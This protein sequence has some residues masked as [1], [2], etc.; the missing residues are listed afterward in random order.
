MKSNRLWWLSLVVGLLL[1]SGDRVVRAAEPVSTMRPQIAQVENTKVLVT[2][3]ELERSSTG[4]NIVLETA[5]GQTL[6]IDRSKFTTAGNAIVADIPN[7]ELSNTQPFEVL[8]P[9]PDI[10]VIRVMPIDSDRLQISVVGD[11]TPPTTPVSLKVGGSSYALNSAPETTEQEVEIVVRGDGRTRYNVPNASTATKTDT[12]LRDVPQSIQVVPRQIIEDQGITRT[13]DALRNTSGISIQGGYGGYY[14][15]V[16]VRGFLNSENLKNGFATQTPSPVVNS[17]NI[18]QIEVL[19]GPASVLYGQSQ[20]GGVVNYVT[21]KPLE[22]P[23]RSAEVKF[24]SFNTFSPSIDLSGPLD[25]NKTLL[26]RFN[27]NYSSTGSFIDFVDGN[28]FNAAVALTYKISPATTIDLEY[29]RSDDR[30]TFYDGLPVSPVAFQLPINSFFGDPNGP[31]L[32]ASNNNLSLAVNHKF[33]DDLK[34]RSR[35]GA[36]FGTFANAA[37]RPG[38]LLE[39]QR[40]LTL[41]FQEDDKV[42]IGN[43]AWQTDLI[44]KFTTGSIKHQ[45][46]VG[47]DLSRAVYGED[48]YQN[49]SADPATLP[50]IDI[51]NPVYGFT[52]PDRSQLTFEPFRNERNS[53]GIYA[54]DQ[55]ELQPNLKLLVGG[56]F[57]FVDRKDTN[58]G[59]VSTSYDTAFTPR[60][61]IVYQPIQPISLYASYAR[62]FSPSF[63]RTTEGVTLPPEQG[64]QYEVGVK[65]DLAKNV[66]ATLSVYDITKNNVATTDPSDPNASIAA[67]EVKSRGVELDVTGR[68]L[69]GWNITASA[70][71]N[72]TVVSQ[73]NNLP[74]GDRLVNAPS[75]GA[76]MW[77]TYE[78]QSGSL[79]GLGFG[80]GLFFVGNREVEIPNT[81]EFPSYV[82]ADAAIFYKRDDWKVGLNFKNITGTRYFEQGFYPVPGAPFSV[83]GTVSVTF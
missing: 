64:A 1:V 41:T 71:T 74:V 21:K 75:V 11:K 58:S 82:R 60:A 30:R 43:Y 76:S 62:S 22:N 73:D 35:L 50:T 55:I 44:A 4:L 9:A 57:D 12:P 83:Q 65:A 49:F 81:F 34:L 46:L 29:E 18:E 59:V 7:A 20:P 45:A 5:T 25:P 63:S 32:T 31:D 47:V 10:S 19:K 17:T 28:Q 67:G 3:I 79:Q 38:E 51:F 26:Y 77:T 61:G 16:V 42:E 36:Q 27:A 53:V 52:R 56:R 13:S 72:N 78:I 69:P 23:Y 68:I 33:S 70:F 6:Q 54:Q 8:N 15:D 14:D 39:D 48:Y 80:T 66:S 24:G 2:K 37:F 40:T